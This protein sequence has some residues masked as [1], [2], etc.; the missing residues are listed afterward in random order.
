MPRSI[1]QI[2][3]K[4][5]EEASYT[6]ITGAIEEGFVSATPHPDEEIDRPKGYSVTLTLTPESTG[7]AESL[8]AALMDVDPAEMIVHL[9]GAEEPI[10]EL[11]V[12]VSKVPHPGDQNVA[13]L[14]VPPEGH[15]KLHE[16][17]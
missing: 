8:Q 11:P 15:D 3:W 2:K 13:E 4:R 17:F 6:D 7:L 10:T 14:G 16:H 12:S 9:E 5:S 1:Q